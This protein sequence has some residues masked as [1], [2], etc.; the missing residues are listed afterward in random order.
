[1]PGRNDR[2]ARLK[3]AS[4]CVCVCVC[5]CVLALRQTVEVCCRRRCLLLAAGITAKH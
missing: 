4:V 3:W 1:M 5:V 2:A